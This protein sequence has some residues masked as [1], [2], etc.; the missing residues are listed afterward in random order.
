MSRVCIL[1]YVSVTMM[2]ITPVNGIMIHRKQQK[3]KIMWL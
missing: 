3:I 1:G 2:F